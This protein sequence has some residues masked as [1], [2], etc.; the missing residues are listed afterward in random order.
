M[1]PPFY[2]RSYEEG[3]GS[4]NLRFPDPEL[5]LRHERR[6]VGVYD[7]I[8][9]PPAIIR[10]NVRIPILMSAKNGEPIC[11]SHVVV[12]VPIL[13]VKCGRIRHYG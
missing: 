3:R 6:V 2:F 4:G 11:M 9:S 1:T 8:L 12:L 13:A 7:R 10:E 5:L